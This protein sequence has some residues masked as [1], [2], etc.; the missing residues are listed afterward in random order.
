MGENRGEKNKIKAFIAKRK[1]VIFGMEA[2]LWI[3]TS[4]VQV[5]V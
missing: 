3:V 4:V 5:G 2:T 1:A